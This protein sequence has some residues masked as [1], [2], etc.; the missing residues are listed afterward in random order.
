MQLNEATYALKNVIAPVQQHE[1]PATLLPVYVGLPRI[2]D[3]RR[4]STNILPAS[5]KVT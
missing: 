3:M 5:T 2:P 1:R 4:F